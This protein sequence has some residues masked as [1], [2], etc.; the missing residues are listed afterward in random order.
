M[1]AHLNLPLAHESVVSGDQFE[2][3][4]DPADLIRE[5]AVF[6]RVAPRQKL[7]VIIAL[8]SGV[9]HHVGMTGGDGVNDV[10]PIKRA[11]L[12]NA[13]V[14]WKQRRPNRRGTCAGEQQLRPAAGHAERGAAPSS[15][16][17]SGRS[18]L[19]LLVPSMLLLTVIGFGVL[20]GFP[21]EPQ[22][23]TL[24]NAFTIGGPGFSHHVSI[25]KPTDLRRADFPR[26]GVLPDGLCASTGLVMGLCGWPSG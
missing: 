5:H 24:L 15:A 4:V 21:C 7:D 2:S 3:A 20:L 12:G 16:T 9:G 6:G 26:K 19:F 11:D 14:R 23:V 18:K 1:V 13:M 22:Q 8:A 25:G 17:G 10:L